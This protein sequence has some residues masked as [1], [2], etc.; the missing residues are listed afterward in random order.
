MDA[1]LPPDSL[2]MYLLNLVVLIG[3]LIFM[4]WKRDSI[5]KLMTAGRVQSL[6]GN[7]MNNVKNSMVNPAMNAAKSG[8]GMMNPAL[9]AAMNKVGGLRESASA[10]GQNALQEGSSGNAHEKEQR[11][12]QTNNHETPKSAS[13]A[14]KNT[15][16]RTP[17][18]KSQHEN[19]KESKVKEQNIS[20][21]DG[22]F[23]PVSKRKEEHSLPKD[24]TN[25]HPVRH[26]QN[27]SENETSDQNSHLRLVEKEDSSSSVRGGDK[28]N[29]GIERTLQ[30]DGKGSDL[31]P[32]VRSGDKQEYGDDNR[33]SRVERSQLKN[34]SSNDKSS[35]KV[36]NVETSSHQKLK[37]DAE[38]KTEK[39]IQ[40]IDK[41]K[42][43]HA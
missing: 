24:E 3:V 19:E 9:Y 6:D 4:I 12:A 35:R 15:I 20:R 36:K 10:E 40:T 18:D 14:N 34:H 27:V 8:I 5:V 11:T 37:D 17:Q 29:R 21:G 41:D 30:S 28:R 25:T 7:M 31:E 26:T 33:G 16:E 22:D 43:R 32:S 13:T 42:N 23:N 38:R 2:G 1:M 39:E